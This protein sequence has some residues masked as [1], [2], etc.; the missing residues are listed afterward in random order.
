MRLSDFSQVIQYARQQQCGIIE[1][2]P[3]QLHRPA[4]DYIIDDNPLKQNLFSPSHWSTERICCLGLQPW[5]AVTKE[6]EDL[7]QVMGQV[8][9]GEVFKGDKVW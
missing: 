3:S 9:W 8:I 1:R 2:Q 7:R 6:Q 4:L 5:P